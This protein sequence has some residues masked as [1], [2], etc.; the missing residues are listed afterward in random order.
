MM[1]KP[2]GPARTTVPNRREIRVVPNEV[3]GTRWLETMAER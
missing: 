3:G 2:T 1:S